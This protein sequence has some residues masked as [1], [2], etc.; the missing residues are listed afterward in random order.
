VEFPLGKRV[1][2]LEKKKMSSPFK[3]NN[4]SFYTADTLQIK[5]K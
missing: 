1:G 5:V 2:S 3:N 4:N